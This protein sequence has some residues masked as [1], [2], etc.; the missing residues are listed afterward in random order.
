[1]PT[2]KAASSAR[3]TLES[4]VEEPTPEEQEN[5]LART[6]AEKPELKLKALGVTANAPGLGVSDAD[7]KKR[8]RKLLGANKTLFDDDDEETAPKVQKTQLAPGRK[9]KAPLGGLNNAF[10]GKTFSPL[11]RDRRGVHASFLA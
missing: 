10:A 8:K 3:K 1:M 7:A 2:A 9:L 11:K 4:V 6:F 5:K